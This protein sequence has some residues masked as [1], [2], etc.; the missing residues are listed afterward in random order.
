MKLSEQEIVRKLLESDEEFQSLHEQHRDM[1]KQL[2][3]FDDKVYLTPDE[4]MK[5]KN[6]KKRKLQGKDKMYAKI[7]HYKRGIVTGP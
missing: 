1:E 6:L 3:Q 7:N 5:V 2:A 4:Q